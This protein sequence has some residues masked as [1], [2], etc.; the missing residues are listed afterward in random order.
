[1]AVEVLHDSPARV[2]TISAA[3][4]HQELARYIRYDVDLS[5]LFSRLFR[6]LTFVMS[7]MTERGVFSPPIRPGRIDLYLADASISEAVRKDELICW[8][9]TVFHRSLPPRQGELVDCCT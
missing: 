5:W 3:L 9:L 4:R 6:Q 8:L 7:W 1:M 2:S